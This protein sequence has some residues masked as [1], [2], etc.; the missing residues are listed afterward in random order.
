M[1]HSVLAAHRAL[2]AVGLVG[3]AFMGL[4]F[5]ASAQIPGP[6]DVD[7][8]V[9]GFLAREAGVAESE[10]QILRIEGVLFPDTCL[11]LPAET[12]GLEGDTCAPN[13]LAWG[14]LVWAEAGGTVYR[15]HGDDERFLIAA[16]D[17]PGASV[18]T[19][20]LPEGIVL[21][22]VYESMVPEHGVA[23]LTAWVDTTAPKI[24]ETLVCRGCG[25]VSLAVSRSGRFVTWVPNA[26]AFVN[27]QFPDLLEAGSPFIARCS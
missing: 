13:D 19:A 11:G 27:A 25:P 23:L 1:K 14:F 7:R 24:E 8:T 2:L 5:L 15:I 22:V 18:P 9:R 20:S 21:W 17:I 10:V 26:P 4:V 6:V 16:R 3:L 12:P